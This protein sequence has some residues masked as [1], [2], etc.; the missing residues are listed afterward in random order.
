MKTH[1]EIE[2][3]KY[4][5][6]D[7]TFFLE[8]R[9]RQHMIG[10][11]NPNLVKC[12]YFNNG[13][14]CPYEELGCKFD[15]SKSKMCKDFHSCGRNMCQFRHK[16]TED[17]S[18]SAESEDNDQSKSENHSDDND[19]VYPCLSCEFVFDDLDDLIDHNGETGH[20]IEY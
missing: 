3:F 10:H 12:H 6:C 17:A 1:D 16:S 20:N 8:W 13:K 4:E 11:Q 18:S 14:C 5:L 9:L 19:E 7:K 2:T 15:H